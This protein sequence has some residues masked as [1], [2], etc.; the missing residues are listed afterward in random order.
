MVTS[1]LDPVVRPWKSYLATVSDW[2]RLV[3]GVTPKETGCGPV[4][5]L[6]N[7]IERPGESFAIADMRQI[8]V[9]EPHYHTG[10]ETEIYF[11]VEGRGTVVVGG[12]EISVAKGSVVITPPE[13]AHF[14]ISHG[15]VLAVVNTPPFD[16][17]NYVVLTG[18][19]PEVGFD[20]EQLAR[21]SA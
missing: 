14:T 13:T 18:S 6:P 5:E 3:K 8:K 9:A 16:P 21:L 20:Q 10:G 19:K 15:L 11:I 2:H 1:A 12:R 7:P 4:Y 17:A